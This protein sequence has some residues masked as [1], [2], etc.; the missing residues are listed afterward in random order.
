MLSRMFLS[1]TGLLVASATTSYLTESHHP[2]NQTTCLQIE[3]T[4]IA[5]VT[6][7]KTMNFAAEVVLGQGFTG[8]SGV[9]F[10][11]SLRCQRSARHH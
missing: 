9:A 11:S 6:A 10:L 8:D 1:L 3:R 7:T 5:I 2:D 4:S